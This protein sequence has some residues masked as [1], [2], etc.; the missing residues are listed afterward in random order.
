MLLTRAQASSHVRP[1]GACTR[2]RSPDTGPAGSMCLVCEA[3]Q[4]RL[5]HAA[6]T[7]RGVLESLNRLQHLSTTVSSRFM[8]ATVFSM[9][10]F[11]TSFPTAAGM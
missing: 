5:I 3:C 2:A 1:Q 7:Q 9:T 6:W 11:S 10:Y 8:A 4:G